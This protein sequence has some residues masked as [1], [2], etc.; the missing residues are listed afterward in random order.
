M[1]ENLKSMA[2]LGGLLK[3]LPKI[4]EEWHSELA[5]QAAAD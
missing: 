2:S 5:R 4:K 3:D 1:L